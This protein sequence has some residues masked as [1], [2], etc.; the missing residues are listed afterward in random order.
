MDVG[1]FFCQ[2]MLLSVVPLLIVALGGI[3]SEKG[4]VLNFSL[5]GLMLAGA[6]AGAFFLRATQEAVSGNG[7]YFLALLVAG[8]AGMLTMILQGIAAINLNGEQ[9]ISGMAINLLIPALTIVIARAVIGVLQ[10]GYR[11]VFRIPEVPFFSKI[12]VIGDIFFKNAYISTLVGLAVLI[13][14]IFVFKYTR[15]GMRLKACG[16]HPQAAATMGVNVK[17]TRYIGLLISGFLAGLGGLAFVVPNATEYSATVAGYGYLAVAVVIFGQWQPA[18]ILWASLF[19]GAIKT[20][21]NVYTSIPIL[22]GMGASNYLFKMTP[23]VATILVLLFTSRKSKQPAA[24]GEP[25][26]RA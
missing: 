23:Y 20:L 5:E 22:A 9:I 10:V 4:G 21:A 6:F 14:S 16:E 12:P 24:L 15:F 25:Y 19:F 3:F 7:M 1:Y 13:L 17:K 26:D 18:H 8:A 2:Q 11:N